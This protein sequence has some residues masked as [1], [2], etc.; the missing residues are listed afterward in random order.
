MSVLNLL[1]QFNATHL[2]MVGASAIALFVLW[3]IFVYLRSPLRK[4][5]GPFWARWT[6]IWRLYHAW[7][8]KYQWTIEKLHNKYGPVIRIGP[9][10]LDL[11]YPELIKTIY[12]TD[13][14]WKKTEFYHNSSAIIDGKITYHLFSTTDQADHARM[15]RPIAKYY[16][17]SSVLAME[18][19]VNAVLNDLCKHLEE[20]FMDGANAGKDGDLGEWIAYYTWD[21]ISAATF[22]HRFGYMDKAHDFD[23]TIHIADQVADYQ[24]IVGQM[25]FLDFVLDKNP[26][27]RI[28]PP[29]L[30]NVTRISHE[31]M[32]QRLQDDADGK[33]ESKALDKRDFLDHFI[34]AKKNAPSVVDNKIIMGYLQVNMLAGADTTAITLRAIFHFLLTNPPVLAKLEDAVVNANFDLSDGIVPYAAA[35]ALPYLDGVVRESMRMHP[36]V[37]LLL[38]RY[39]PDT[40]L[41][42]PDGSFVPPGTAVGLNPYVLGRNKSVW[43]P[44]ADEFKPERWLS[45]EGE[46]DA[47]YQQR[48]REMNA[49]DLTFGGGSR[50]CIGRHVA[51]LETY[52]VVAT[53]L[54]RYRLLPA[55]EPVPF[56][57]RSTWFPRQRGLVCRLKKRQ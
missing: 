18:P 37:G 46:S 40:G 25:P 21:F 3:N 44:D 49:A 41:T 13:G 10:L 12:G 19:Q 6:N 54:A 48:L 24:A 47:D 16:S 8:G 1:Q 55:K 17:M 11:D 14:K 52:K 43:G 20:R 27:M 30:Q 15:K 28:G 5:P 35:R 38:E 7:S 22:S 23:G 36:G 45:R 42:L 32:V 39:V 4:Y 2:L 51:M 57:I 31:R 33:L 26:V 9:N 53:L 56:V 50:I 34:E 29:N